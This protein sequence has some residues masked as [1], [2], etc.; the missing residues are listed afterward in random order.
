MCNLYVSFCSSDVWVPSLRRT[1]IKDVISG[2]YVC[3]L[4]TGQVSQGKGGERLQSCRFLHI[5]A[6]STCRGR[7]RWRQQTNTWSASATTLNSSAFRRSS[8]GDLRRSDSVG[9]L[10]TCLTNAEDNKTIAKPHKFQL[11]P[12]RTPPTCIFLDGVRASVAGPTPPTPT[13]IIC[14]NKQIRFFV[15]SN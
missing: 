5:Q 9:L 1:S 6:T 11:T 12:S 4:D 14:F 8:L 7:W 2:A 15:S 10:R 3:S 13:R